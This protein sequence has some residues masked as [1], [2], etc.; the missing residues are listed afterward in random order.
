MASQRRGTLLGVEKNFETRLRSSSEIVTTEGKCFELV[1]EII[2]PL[3]ESAHKGQLGRV[4][5]VGGCQE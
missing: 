5:V 4:G 3:L 2:P 1:K